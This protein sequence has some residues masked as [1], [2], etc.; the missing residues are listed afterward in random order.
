MMSLKNGI[1]IS[2]ILHSGLTSP[3][4]WPFSQRIKVTF[5]FPLKENFQRNSA[6]YHL[7]LKVSPPRAGGDKGE[8]KSSL[9]TLP[10]TLSRRRE[11]KNLSSAGIY[12]LRQRGELLM[13]FAP[14]KWRRYNCWRFP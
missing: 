3:K 14:S 5:S 4:E 7:P 13:N 9:F 10:P 11:R 6:N 2:G 12:P 8:L 1:P